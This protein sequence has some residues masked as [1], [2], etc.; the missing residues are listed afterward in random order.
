MKIGCCLPG[1]FQAPGHVGEVTLLSALEEGYRYV[2]DVGY[3][4]IEF[5]VG[6][7]AGMTEA[8]FEQAV[9]LH[10]D[11][12]LTIEACNCFIP[13]SIPLVGENADQAVITAYLEKA[14]PRMAA[15]GVETVVFG[16]GAARKIP[17][18]TSAAQAQEQLDWFMRTAEKIARNVGITI[19]I[20]PLNRGE[21][22]VFLSVQ[23]GGEVA[24][25]L[26]LPNLK[27]LADVYHMYKENE[28]INT[29]IR[30]GD[31]LR[32]IHVAEPVK[33][34]AP[35]DCAYLRQ[36]SAA[37]REAGYDGRVSIEGSLP[38]FAEELRQVQ[39]LMRDLF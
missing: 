31:L 25:R 3:D 18:G 4:Y 7:I 35:E 9:Q 22:N 2:L 27:L 21:T 15:L 16:S 13:G 20:E 34:T 14:L 28:P 26:D 39:P 17:E 37:L 24:R 36:F 6:G 19:V 32:H 11:G 12:K 1:N 8:E 29:V 33:R 10:K 30:N 23:E 5:N 38:E